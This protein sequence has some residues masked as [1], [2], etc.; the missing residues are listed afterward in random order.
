MKE[1]NIYLTDAD[2][3]SLKNK[4]HLEYRDRRSGN[5]IRLH[6]IDSNI[7]NISKAEEE[8][9]VSKSFW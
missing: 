5:N 6:Y 3:E 1:I 4:E 9:E 8:S 2:I 7:P